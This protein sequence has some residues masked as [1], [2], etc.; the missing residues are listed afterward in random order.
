MKEKY[1][2]VEV[3]EMAV[4]EVEEFDELESAVNY[5]KKLTSEADIA[6]GGF[7][8]DFE[9]FV[10][11]LNNTCTFLYINKYGTKH[12]ITILAKRIN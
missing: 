12:S 11:G 6:D 1:F 8:D 3:E 2:V 5:Y 7:E 10:E 4:T 9:A